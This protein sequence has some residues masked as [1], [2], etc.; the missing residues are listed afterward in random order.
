MSSSGIQP[1]IPPSQNSQSH[2]LDNAATGID[3]YM[4]IRVKV[5]HFEKLHISCSVILLL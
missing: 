2:F 3:N 5:S 4:G 1:E